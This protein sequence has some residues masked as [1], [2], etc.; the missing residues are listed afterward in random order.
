MDSFCTKC[1]ADY[2]PKCHCNEKEDFRKGV[3]WCVKMLRELQDQPNHQKRWS[4]SRDI[5]FSPVELS[6]YLV[7][8]YKESK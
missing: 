6:D 7:S 8:K 2:E 4:H 3:E 5:K 1:F